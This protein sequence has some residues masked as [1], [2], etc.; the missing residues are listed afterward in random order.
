MT[1]QDQRPRF[2]EGQFLAAD[3]INAI[4]DYGH[5]Q[6]VRHELG[7]H[8]WG[9]MTGLKLVERPTPGAPKRQ[10]VLIMPGVAEDGYGRKLLVPAAALLSEALFAKIPYASDVDDPAS[11]NGIP[12]GRFVK[13]WLAYDEQSGKAPPAGFAACDAGNEYAR[14]VEGYRFLIGDQPDTHK[15]SVAGQTVNAN[16]ALQSALDPTAPLLADESVPQQQFPSDNLTARWPVPIGWVRWVVDKNGGGYFVDRNIDPADLGD[17]R[18]RRFRRYVGVIAENLQAP[19][20]ALV[21][22]NRLSDPNGD[23][24]FQAR[25]QSSAALHDTLQDIVWVEGN[26]RAVGDIRLADGALRL[27]D[28]NGTDQGTPLS[29]ERIGD[30]PSVAGKRSLDALIGPDTQADNRF[31]VATVVKDDPDPAKRQLGEKLSVLSG[32][33][34]GIG[35][36]SPAQKLHVVGNRVRLD[37]GGGTKVLDLRTDD[38]ALTSVESRTSDLCLRATGG[39]PAHNLVLNPDSTDGNVGIGIASPAYKLDVKAK[40]IK[41]GLEDNGG[42]QLILSGDTN[43]IYLAGSNAAGTGSA[44]EMRITG[45][46]GANIQKLALAADTVLVKGNALRLENT[47][48]TKNL[49]LFDTGSEVDLYTDSNHLSLRSAN[50]DCLINWIAGDGNVGIGTGSPSAKLHVAGEFLRV[51]GNGLEWAYLG[52]DGNAND[53]QIGSMNPGVTR[54][55]AWNAGSNAPMQMAAA[56]WATVSDA[57][58]KTNI[59]PVTNALD[60]VCR[61]RGVRFDWRHE[62]NPEQRS[63]VGFIAQ[64]V[65][66][67]VPEAVGNTR[68]YATVSYDSIVPVLAE[69]VKELKRENDALR[70]ELKRLN[71]AVA[72]LAAQLKADLKGQ[73]A[74]SKGKARMPPEKDS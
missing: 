25:L 26:L 11:T 58:L 66:E 45:R 15:V 24:C 53:V 32:G 36:D 35:N 74:Q 1:T 70:E 59:R 52:G 10:N 30:K 9:I 39:A 2:Y 20:G 63:A 14:V 60:L 54:I 62:K 67:V 72:L 41:L 18:I 19:D 46:N 5:D 4:V 16:Q 71:G 43:N 57:S 42:G 64:E 73:E 3:D 27:A 17:D 7:A 56:S 37:S 51:D 29:I 69:S 13:I 8:G 65:A 44:A 47:A 23:G 33:N 6:I 48:G 31:A 21:L 50:H 12:P 68:S 49:M 38:A 55:S 34:V 28:V 22:R 40:A 61:L